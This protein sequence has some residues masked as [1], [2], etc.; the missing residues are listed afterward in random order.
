[1]GAEM[2]SKYCGM[3]ENPFIE[4]PRD[5]YL[6]SSF[7][8]ALA[9][10]YY[11]LEYG[12]G[13]LLLSGEP[14]SGKT[15]LLRHFQRRIVRRVRT[16]FLSCTGRDASGILSYALT[17]RGIE[18]EDR[19]LPWMQRRLDQILIDQAEPLVL[20]LD[21]AQSSSQAIDQ[22]PDLEAFK[23][24]LL[25]IAVAGTVSSGMQLT[26]SDF[27][28]GLHRVDL[29]PLALPEVAHYIDYRLRLAGWDGEPLFAKDAYAL[30]AEQ[31]QGLVA[32]INN[33]CSSAILSGAKQ[34][35]KPID[36]AMLRAID[37]SLPSVPSVMPAPPQ[38][39]KRRVGTAVWSAV[40]I[41]LPSSRSPSSEAPAP[42]LNSAVTSNGP[43][44]YDLGTADKAEV[45]PNKETQPQEAQQ[46]SYA[47]RESRFRQNFESLYGSERSYAEY[48]PAYR[49][50]YSLAINPRYIG[51]D[52]RAVESDIKHDWEKHGGGRWDK[53]KG[54]IQYAWLSASIQD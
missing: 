35:I 2:L 9:G 23:R 50:G 6:S 34:G 44:G 46:A 36:E 52:W 10:L 48:E 11:G 45:K 21:D 32:W 27:V 12:R 14:G 43:S 17:E 49:F 37:A 18:P 30:I 1:M 51:K 4:T 28:R 42:Q 39:V 25:T 54:S 40:T 19:D 31:S 15:T 7:R 33:I 24:G 26:G 13:R 8:E 38:P 41:Y 5:P 29:T 3:S 16:L 20:I 47:T 53:Y 22:L